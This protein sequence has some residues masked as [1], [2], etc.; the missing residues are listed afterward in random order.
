M[1]THRTRIFAI[2]SLLALTVVLG[3][4]CCLQLGDRKAIQERIRRLKEQ[5]GQ[6]YA[7]G[8]IRGRILDRKGRILAHDQAVFSV[9][10]AYQLT[11]YADPNVTQA[12]RLNAL[13]R[14]NPARALADLEQMAARNTAILEQ[15]VAGCSRFGDPCEV[16]WTRIRRYNQWIWSHRLFQAWRRHCQGTELYKKF[17]DRINAVPL[18]QA[19]AD[20]QAHVDDP[21]QVLILA[22]KIDL[23]EMHGS[24]SLVD[25]KT[26]DDVLAAELEFNGIKGVKVEPRPIRLYP[27]GPA[28]CHIIG[29]VGAATQQ[30]DLDLFDQD[31][32]RRYLPG[33]VCGREDGVEYVCEVLLRGSRGKETYDVDGRQ[34]GRAHV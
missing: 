4:L 3:R 6:T 29:W 5:Q 1:D 13:Q 28:A 23:A 18:Q 32:Q 2:M 17:A 31:P 16:L 22:G 20:L 30:A 26:D 14:K 19:I 12:R 27:Y 8:T 25:L 9:R 24:M 34:I 33:D 10:V 11:Q 7:L 21:N 15:V